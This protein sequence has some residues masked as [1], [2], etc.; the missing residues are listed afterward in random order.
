MK[1]IVFLFAI[2]LCFAAYS[3]S[4]IIKIP[5]F[6]GKTLDEVNALNKAN[7]NQFTTTHA[8]SSLISLIFQDPV[9]ELDYEF[10]FSKD[11]VCMAYVTQTQDKKT[12]DELVKEIE[13][14]CPEKL[15]EKVWLQKL[16]GKNYVW[17][18]QGSDAFFAFS[19]SQSK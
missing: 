16:D 13:K 4:F 19:V 18:L 10:W 14:K 12:K 3:Q 15:N 6:I 8:D 5:T 11:K 17:T 7:N 2:L 1:K 9:I